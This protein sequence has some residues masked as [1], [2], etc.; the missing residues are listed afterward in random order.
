MIEPLPE[1]IGRAVRRTQLIY[2]YVNRL[3]SSVMREFYARKKKRGYFLSNENAM[4][5]RDGC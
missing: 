2:V 1:C 4:R 3:D 5:V